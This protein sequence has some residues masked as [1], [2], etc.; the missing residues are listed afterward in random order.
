MVSMQTPSD[1]LAENGKR[2]GSR[3]YDEVGHGGSGSRIGERLQHQILGT[4]LFVDVPLL[5]RDTKWGESAFRRLKSRKDMLYTSVK[6]AWVR[7]DRW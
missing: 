2:Q 6:I 1:W 7:I 3:P 5:W 4:L